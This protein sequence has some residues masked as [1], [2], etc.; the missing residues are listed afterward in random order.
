MQI[1]VKSENLFPFQK[2]ES[3]QKEEFGYQTT[4]G[5]VAILVKKVDDNYE[6]RIDERFCERVEPVSM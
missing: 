3:A 5:D 6:I 4:S 1:F 2:K